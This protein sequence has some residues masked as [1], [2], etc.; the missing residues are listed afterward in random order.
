MG[1][2]LRGT[3]P[4]PKDNNDLY[5][6]ILKNTLKQSDIT[7]EFCSVGEYA[8]EAV[9]L[10]RNT[11]SW[12]VYEGERGKKY[13]IKT[14]MNCREACYDVISRVAESS[15]AEKELKDSFNREFEKSR[16]NRLGYADYTKTISKTEIVPAVGTAIR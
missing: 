1:N 8:E 10:E 4:A 9:C 12:I 2:T 5:I 14:H 15:D 11:P 16:F 13:N 3:Q 7:D 6:Q